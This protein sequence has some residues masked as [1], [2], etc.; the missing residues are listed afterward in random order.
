MSITIVSVTA[1]RTEWTRVSKLVDPGEVLVAV[2]SKVKYKIIPVV[3]APNDVG[4]TLSPAELKEIGQSREDIKHQRTISG[5][6]NT[7]MKHIVA[8]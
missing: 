4:Y 8:K 7:I 1:V 3:S 5:D 2:N 6:A